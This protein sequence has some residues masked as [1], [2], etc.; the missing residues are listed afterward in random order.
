MTDP[1]AARKLAEEYVLELIEN[2]FRKGPGYGSPYECFHSSGFRQNP[3]YM[4]SVTC[5]YIVFKKLK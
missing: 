2:D 3:V 1:E 5:P 4:A